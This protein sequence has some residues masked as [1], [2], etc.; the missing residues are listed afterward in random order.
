V[1]LSSIGCFRF[2][3][4]PLAMLLQM[5]GDVVACQATHIH[6]TQD[7]SGHSSVT[8]EIDR[9]FEALVQCFGPEQTLL[10]A[11]QN[12]RGIVRKCWHLFLRGRSTDFPAHRARSIAFV[13][14]SERV[15]K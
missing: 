8:E 6:H 2:R 14:V 12:Q 11:C 3:D 10:I 9:T 4:A 15:R 7:R 1:W 13:R 5:R